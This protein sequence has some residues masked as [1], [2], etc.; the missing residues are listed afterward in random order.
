MFYGYTPSPHACNR[1]HEFPVISLLKL[2]L[3]VWLRKLSLWLRKLRLWLRKLS[4]RRFLRVE[5]YN[6]ALLQCM[7]PSNKSSLP[8][9]SFCTDMTR[10][11]GGQN[12]SSPRLIASTLNRS[13]FF[14][15]QPPPLPSTPHCPSPTCTSSPSSTQSCIDSTS[16]ALSPHPS[17]SASPDATRKARSRPQQLLLP[18]KIKRSADYDYDYDYNDADNDSNNCCSESS[19]SNAKKISRKSRELCHNEGIQ[20]RHHQ[21]TTTTSSLDPLRSSLLC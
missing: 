20:R 16:S 17:I 19:N 7:L 6:C 14:P 11:C 21:S 10:G 9:L 1:Q 15:A 2:S 18:A 13:G 3:H 12:R 5:L 8:L 4:Q